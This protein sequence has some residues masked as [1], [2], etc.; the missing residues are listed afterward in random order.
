VKMKN[1]KTVGIVLLVVGIILSILSLIADRIGI[2]AAPGF[3]MNQII[4]TT[5]GV[6]MAVAGL[7]LTIRK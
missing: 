7:V 2:G 3:G 6:I 1:K 4:A 5:V